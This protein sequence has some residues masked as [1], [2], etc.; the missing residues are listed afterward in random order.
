MQH[1][2]MQVESATEKVLGPS[3]MTEQAIEVEKGNFCQDL[4]SSMPLD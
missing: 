4:N 3:G 1:L 2:G